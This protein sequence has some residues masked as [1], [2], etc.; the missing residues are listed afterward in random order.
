MKRIVVFVGIVALSIGL[1]SCAGNQSVEEVAT[2]VV[3]VVEVTA[4]RSNSRK[5]RIFI[6]H[7]G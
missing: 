7:G 3:E 1:G 2:E 4:I 6:Q 5:A